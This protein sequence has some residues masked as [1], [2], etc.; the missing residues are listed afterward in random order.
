MLLL[1]N[2]AICFCK[3]AKHSIKEDHYED[4]HALLVKA[5]N[6]V[7]QLPSGLR[8]DVCP[9]LV[10]KIG[11][12]FRFVFYRLFEADLSR[13]PHRIDEAIQLFTTLRNAWVEAVERA[14]SQTCRVLSSAAAERLDLSV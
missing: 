10:D 5:E 6:I 1:Y 13:N 11:Q 2:A 7:M 9:Q 3:E 12:L 4:A 8:R 14:G